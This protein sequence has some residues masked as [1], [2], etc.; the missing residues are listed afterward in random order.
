MSLSL[1]E[2][3]NRMNITWDV[4][5][6]TIFVLQKW[7]FSF[8]TTDEASAWTKRE[9]EVFCQR[10]ESL[11]LD[12]WSSKAY[13][14]IRD[15]PRIHYNI[16]IRI[17]NLFD[18]ELSDNYHWDVRVWKFVNDRTDRSNGVPINSVDNKLTNLVNWSKRIIQLRY[19]SVH[20]TI[21]NEELSQYGLVH[22][23]GHTFCNPD[24]DTIMLRP[25]FLNDEK[26][27]LLFGNEVRKRHF[28]YLKG[29]LRKMRNLESG[30]IEIYL[31]E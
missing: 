8:H 15:Q 4:N 31:H 22:E 28:D 27:I 25:L 2:N 5:S 29:L 16:N 1:T 30:Q 11:I 9:K 6:R 21:Y 3:G 17:R 13:A 10:A 26:S 19:D 24:E 7:K 18:R 23:M 14:V 20:P 12:Y